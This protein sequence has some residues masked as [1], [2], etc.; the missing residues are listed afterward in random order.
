M[1]ER[2]KKLSI[3][4]V[5]LLI[6][7]I[8]L[9]LFTRIRNQPTPIGL[10]SQPTPIPTP[11]TVYSFESLHGHTFSPVSI[12]VGRIVR[13]SPDFLAQLFYFTFPPNPSQSEV[14]TVSGV[15]TV[16]K[17]D[18]IYPVIV[19]MRGYIPSDTYTEGAGTQPSA[20]VFA[21]HGFITLAPDFLGFGE[22]DSKAD[23]QFES[24]FQT[25]TTALTLLA[26]LP[27]LNEG[28][29]ASY[30]G[31][32]TADSSNVGLW[33]HSNGG[34]IALSTLAI[35]GR[36]YPTVLWAPVS[37]SFPY[38]NLA[39]TDEDDDQGKAYRKDLS[40]FEEQYDTDLFSP[41]KYFSWI[42]APIQIHQGTNDVEVPYWWSD[43]LVD[44]LKKLKLTVD[45]KK[46]PGS[47]HNLRPGWNEV[48][49][50]SVEFY[51]LS[52]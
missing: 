9:F 37:K 6:G 42:T 38:S 47:D 12:R 26:S 35:S 24:R 22:S 33:G 48:V 23:D 46:Y 2:M 15:I 21:A 16:P 13:E 51:T 19:M 28:L 27:N 31:K 14:K 20:S 7:W 17:K 3:I 43:A 49:D 45:Y 11:L 40:V 44:T 36:P 10:L 32:I 1:V 39:Y 25:Y 52:L 41:P 34:H 50:K 30:S 18:G 8:I 4:P 5:L 29:M